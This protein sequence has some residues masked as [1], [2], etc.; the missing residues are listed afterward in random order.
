MK[1]RV[2]LTLG[3][4]LCGKVM[5][6]DGHPGYPDGFYV[7]IPSGMQNRQEILVEGCGMPRSSLSGFGDAVLLLSVIATKEEKTLLENKKAVFQDLFSINP[8]LSETS[9]LLWQAKPIS[10]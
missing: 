3:E 1:L 4:A 6:L 10:Y 9:T 2:S 8:S 5:K 7:Q